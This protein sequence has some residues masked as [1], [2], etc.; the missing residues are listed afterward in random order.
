MAV[1]KFSLKLSVYTREGSQQRVLISSS[2][3]VSPGSGTCAWLPLLPLPPPPLAGL[4]CC[5][6]VISAIRLSIC[7]SRSRMDI[8]NWLSRAEQEYQ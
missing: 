7:S 2:A 1:K 3:W 8:L 4:C 5:D 6:P